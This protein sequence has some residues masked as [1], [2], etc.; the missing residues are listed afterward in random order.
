MLQQEIEVRPTF[1][2]N[3]HEFKVTYKPSE[4]PKVFIHVNSRAELE[5]GLRLLIERVSPKVPDVEFHVYGRVS[6]Q[7]C[8]TNVIFHGYIPETQFNEEIKNYQ[9]AVRLHE[10]D[11]FAETLS[12]SIL[13]GQYPISRIRYPYIDSYKDEEKLIKLLK[14]L[15]NKKKPNY[16]ARDYYLKQFCKYD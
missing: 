9:A 4:T 2:S 6:P 12:K 16:K 3:P 11:G 8:R 7:R 5:S 14:D 15:K 13:N 1:L 10:F